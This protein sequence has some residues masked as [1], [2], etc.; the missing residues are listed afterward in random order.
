MDLALMVDKYN[1]VSGVGCLGFWLK[2]SIGAVLFEEHA[3]EKEA[4]MVQ[5]SN[6]AVPME[7]I[8]KL[9]IKIVSSPRHASFFA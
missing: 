1:D 5:D 9:K 8:D 2:Q 4:T 6:S 7:S 3:E